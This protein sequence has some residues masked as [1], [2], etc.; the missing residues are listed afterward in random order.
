MLAPTLEE[1]DPDARFDVITCAQVLE[2]IPAPADALMR[3]VA[4]HLAPGGVVLIETWDAQSRAARWFG[5]RWHQLA[6]PTVRCW[7]T[8]RSLRVAAEGAGLAV[9]EVDR[10]GKRLTVDWCLAIAE[11]RLLPRL[12]GVS[13]RMARAVGAA[14][15]PVRYPLDDVLRVVLRDQRKSASTL[16]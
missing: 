7:F 5:P 13:R 8:E 6:P 15:W 3:R 11:A 4:G 2:H 16:E 1:F 9:L 10:P 12:V 14:D